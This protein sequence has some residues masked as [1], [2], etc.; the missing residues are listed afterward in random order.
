V[1]GDEWIF[2]KLAA[3]RRA[4]AWT[5]VW[6]V[7]LVLAVYRTLT[8][9]GWHRAWDVVLALLFLFLSAFLDSLPRWRGA[10]AERSEA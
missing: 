9:G 10:G 7:A 3:W 8:V 4:R 6:L 1:K 5:V 2:E